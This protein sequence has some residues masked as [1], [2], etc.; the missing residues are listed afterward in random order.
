[1][2]LRSGVIFALL[3]RTKTMYFAKMLMSIELS[4]CHV[5]HIWII[6]TIWSWE[7]SE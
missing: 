3:H 5:D 2:T 1:M 6:Q 4:K 7:M